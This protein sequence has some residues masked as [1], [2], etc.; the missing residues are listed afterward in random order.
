MK[1]LHLLALMALIMLG[2]SGCEKAAVENVAVA[3]VFIKSIKNSQGT[4]V[5]TAMHSVFSYNKMT[6]VRVTSPTGTTTA[7]KNYENGGYSFYN[8]PTDADYSINLPVVGTYTYTVKFDNGEEK[9]YTN[10]LSDSKILPANI[11]SLVKTAKGDSVYIYW[12]AVANVDFYQITIQHGTEQAF[13]A[14]KLYDASVPKK[15]SVR[16]GF[17]I[18]NLTSSGSGTYTFDITGTLY[19]TSAADYL[20]ALSTSTKDITL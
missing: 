18:N 6:S 1:K 13:H 7:L 15:A 10:S 4:I 17:L 5:Y 3:D 16:L 19:E 20:Q 14:E 2:L 9:I 8:E 11:T 12:D